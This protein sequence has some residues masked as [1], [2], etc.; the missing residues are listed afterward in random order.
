MCEVRVSAAVSR[1]EWVSWPAPPPRLARPD[2][3]GTDEIVELRDDACDSDEELGMLWNGNAWLFCCWGALLRSSITVP[4]L[5]L[6]PV[7][8]LA[9]IPPPG[10][11]EE[12]WLMVDEA[13]G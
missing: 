3:R 5:S 8:L 1:L 7:E 12:E 11:R 4:G 13:D 10:G 6:L 2:V 9:L